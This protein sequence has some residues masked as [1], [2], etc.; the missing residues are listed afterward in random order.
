MTKNG[1]CLK[2]EDLADDKGDED[3]QEAFIEMG[4]DPSEEPVAETEATQAAT[5]APP[6]PSST[7]QAP[8]AELAAGPELPPADRN[9]RRFELTAG[10]SRKF[11]EITVAGTQYTVRFGRLGT[12][13]QTVTKTFEDAAAARRDADRLIRSKQAKGYRT[14]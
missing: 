5:G 7:S 12:K 6:E 3:R 14:V 2:H 4:A 9:T 13:G 1:R 10:K 11:W 8:V